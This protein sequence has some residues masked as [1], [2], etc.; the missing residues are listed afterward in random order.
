MSIILGPIFE[1]VLQIGADAWLSAVNLTPTFSA[2][3]VLLYFGKGA[4]FAVCTIYTDWESLVMTCGFAL[5]NAGQTRSASSQTKENW[6]TKDI[7]SS[8]LFRL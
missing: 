3:G 2:R 1:D 6:Q 7:S 8:V 5:S 4:L